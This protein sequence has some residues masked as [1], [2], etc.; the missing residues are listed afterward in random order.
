MH[1]AAPAVA[2][3]PSFTLPLSGLNRRAYD[4]I[5]PSRVLRCEITTADGSRFVAVVQNLSVRGL[6]VLTDAVLPP[7]T[8]VGVR[9]T[10]PEAM[11]CLDVTLHVLRCNRVL[12][13]DRFVAGVLSRELSPEELRP[14]VG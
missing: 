13:G 12:T 5:R 11:S 8:E 9:L 1:V 10:S 2:F 3:A 4:R 7:G 6:A 14:F